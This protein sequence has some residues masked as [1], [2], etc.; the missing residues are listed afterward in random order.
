MEKFRKYLENI[1]DI[2]NSDWQLLSSKLTRQTIP[3]KTI[4]LKLGEVENC[5][6]FVESGGVRLCIPKVEEDK[7]VTFGF[8]FEGE[9]ISA[10][11]SFLTRTPSMYQLGCHL[12]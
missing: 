8:S 11:D 7:Q 4:I 12:F 5:I 3:K 10:Y 6:S 1:V 2:S 9:L